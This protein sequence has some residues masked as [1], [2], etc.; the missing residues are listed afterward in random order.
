MKNLGSF[1][2]QKQLGQ[3]SELTKSKQ[4]MRQLK[5]SSFHKKHLN[6]SIRPRSCEV[7]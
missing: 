5:P 3:P 6:K 1:M 7:P 2:I 4:L